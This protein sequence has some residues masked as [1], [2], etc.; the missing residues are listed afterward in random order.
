MVSSNLVRGALA[1]SL[2]LALAACGSGSGPKSDPP[3]VTPPPTTPP[4]TPPVTPQPAFDAHLALT[5]TQAAH[6]MGLTGAGYRIGVIDSGVMRNH[7]ALAGRVLANHNYLNPAQNNLSVDDVVGHGTTVAQLA[8]G[9]PTGQWPGGVAP[10]AQ[11]LSARIIA[12]KSPTDDG[13]GNG[14][15]V[16]GALGMASVHADLIRDGM[17]IMNNSWGGLYW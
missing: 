9:A 10:G 6:A 2:A 16:T 11:I 7:P 15:E 5:N 3:P 8:A 4:V 13:S 12:D 17:R 14:N 1:S